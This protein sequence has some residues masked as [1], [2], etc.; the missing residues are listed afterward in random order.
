MTHYYRHEEFCAKIKT[1][2]IKDASHDASHIDADSPEDGDNPDTDSP[3]MGTDTAAENTTPSEVVHDEEFPSVTVRPASKL[4]GGTSVR[5]LDAESRD[6]RTEEIP[7]VLGV[8]PLR[9]TVLFPGIVVPALVGKPRSKALIEAVLADESDDEKYLAVVA[10]RDPE[11]EDLSLDDLYRVGALARVIQ[12]MKQPDGTLRVAIEGVSR[13]VIEEFVQEVPYFRARVS[14]LDTVIADV[15]RVEAMQRSVLGAFQRMVELAPYLPERLVTA[16][17]NV[18]DPE[19]LSD[20]L[21][22]NINTETQERQKIL[23]MDDLADRLQEIL[24]VLTREVSLLEIGTQISEEIQGEMEEQQREFV[25]RRQLEA[26][27]KELGEGDPESEAAELR[28]QVEAS[29]MPTEAREE[30]LRELDRLEKIP[31]VSPEYSVI[32]SYLDWMLAIPWGKVTQDTID[33]HSAKTILD[34]DHHGLDEPKDRILEYLAVRQLKAD[35][36]GPILCFVGPPGVGKT[37]LGQ[38][39]ARALGRKFARMSLGGVRDESELRGHRRTYI[40]AMPGRIVTAL[41]RAEMMNPVIMLDEVDKLGS[42]YRG[43]PASALLEVLDPAQNNTF[44]D[45]YLD[46]PLDLSKVLFIATANVAHTIPGPLLDRMEVIE[47]PGYTDSEKRAIAREYLLPK[48]R[49]EHGLAES[50]FTLEEDA[51]SLVIESYT[52]EAGVRNLD[53][54]LATLIRKTAREIVESD[55]SLA[56]VAIDTERVHAAL[57]PERYT[58]DLAG[59]DDEVGISTGLAWTP[60][61]GDVLFVEVS[62]TPGTGQLI[63]TGQLGEVMQESA[64]AALTYARTRSADFGMG[65]DW[66]QTHDVHVHVPAGA[67]PKDGPSAGITIATALVSA[68]TKRA[69]RREVGMTGEITLRGKV[70][71]IGGLK[72]KLLA[73]HRA[74]L[75]KIILCEKNAKDLVEVPEF[76]K[77]EL[78][79]ILVTHIDEVLKHALL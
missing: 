48:Q 57:G 56:S 54:S 37:S 72:E 47:I 71:P 66:K 39:F 67:I 65:D 7:S 18:G 35:L 14:P 15:D 55:G 16:A 13:V 24:K 27:K 5:I 45:H 6:D 68:I 63:L 40:G 8:L 58:P 36:R 28:T 44:R 62:I 1:M 12:M 70:L 25:L 51:L 59:E 26:I 74:G 10:V 9:D 41:R 79:I 69:V 32:R 43:D 20:F 38:S 75:R 21:G 11:T 17:L 77:E 33:V 78:D 53:R 2:S 52:K 64:Q 19:L 4:S 49:E 34:E 31:S 23:E 76:V 46:V 29:A 60:V 50:Q 42:D 61:G 22:A 73:A 30:A 3:D